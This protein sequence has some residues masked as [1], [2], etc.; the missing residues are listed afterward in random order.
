MH[1]EN[2]LAAAI[3]IAQNAKFIFAST[4]QLYRHGCK[5]NC[6]LN[7]QWAA[8]NLTKLVF[9]KQVTKISSN[10]SGSRFFEA[11]IVGKGR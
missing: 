3:A 5:K 2:S 11:S 7:S 10:Y 1:A 8:E 9:T 6:R 4:A